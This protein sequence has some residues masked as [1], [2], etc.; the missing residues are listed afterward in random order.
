M[1][2]R[3]EANIVGLTAGSESILSLAE[4]GASGVL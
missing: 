3:G 2:L 4:A 1:T